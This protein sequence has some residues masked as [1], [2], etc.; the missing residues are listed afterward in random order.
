MFKSFCERTLVGARQDGQTPTKQAAS[1]TGLQT[2]RH[3]SVVE[4]Q[5]KNFSGPGLLG[6]VVG[7]G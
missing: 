1:G 6:R 7:Q 3:F 2:Q 4:N 5:G